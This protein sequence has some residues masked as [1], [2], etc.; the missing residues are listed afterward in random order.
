MLSSIVVMLSGCEVLHEML[1]ASDAEGSQGILGRVLF[2]PGVPGG[3]PF[4][5]AASFDIRHYV[6]EP[7]HGL[8]GPIIKRFTSQADGSFRVELPAG[9]YCIW[10][11]GCTPVEVPAGKWVDVPLYIALP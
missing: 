9:K 1:L 8:D 7:G 10:W 5:G 2:L 4:P 6:D 3:E 11:G